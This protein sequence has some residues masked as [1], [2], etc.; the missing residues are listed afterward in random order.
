MQARSLAVASA[1]PRPWRWAALAAVLGNVGF[2]YASMALGLRVAETSDRYRTAFTPAGYAFAIWGVIFG[3]MI[4]YAVA[5]RGAA[6]R[7]V[8]WHD[9]V[10]RPLIAT[11]LLC[12]AWVLVFSSGFVAASVPVMFAALLAAGLS[13]ARAKQGLAMANQSRFWAMPMSLLTG[14]LAVASIANVAAALVSLG[15]RGAPFTETA[16]AVGMVAVATVLAGTL[17]LRFVDAVIPIVVCWAVMAIA[18][19][20][21]IARPELAAF[22]VGAGVLCAVIA[23]GVRVGQLFTARSPAR[24]SRPSRPPSARF[25]RSTAH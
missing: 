1:G 25:T 11:N 22:A 12:S 19:Q 3:A 6:Q 9:A 4:V 14:W 7:R 21:Q 5:A 17:A 20:Q 15:W 13:Y 23:V 24:S 10:A 8:G 2:N 18:W 16:W